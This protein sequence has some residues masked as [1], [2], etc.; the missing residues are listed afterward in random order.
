MTWS[1][2]VSREWGKPLLCGSERAAAHHLKLQSRICT[3]ALEDSKSAIIQF[4][5]V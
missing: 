3:A 4:N 2:N 1:R 5:I